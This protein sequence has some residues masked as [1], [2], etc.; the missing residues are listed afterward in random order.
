MRT[1]E[2][3]GRSQTRTATHPDFGSFSLSFHPQPP[4]WTDRKAALEVSTRAPPALGFSDLL[5][6]KKSTVCMG[7]SNK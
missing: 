2:L 6:Q 4:Q 5:G 7:V 1:R 3:L